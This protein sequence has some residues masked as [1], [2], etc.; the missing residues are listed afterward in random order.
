M[1]ACGI[2]RS[3]SKLL[4]DGAWHLAGSELAACAAPN[5]AAGW[6][7]L[8]CR[9][10]GESST[11]RFQTLDLSRSMPA[12]RSCRLTARLPPTGQ[13]HRGQQLGVTFEKTGGYKSCW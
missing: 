13:L 12:C 9:C 6:Q 7:S 1:A 3:S 10:H 2:L 11:T 5:A 8:R 4:H